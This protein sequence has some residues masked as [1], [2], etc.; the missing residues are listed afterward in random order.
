MCI[1]E[2][3]NFKIFRG[4]MPPAPLVY[5]C[6]WQSTLCFRRACYYQLV[7]L[8]IILR[9]L[10]TQKDVSFFSRKGCTFRIMQ[11]YIFQGLLTWGPLKLK[12]HPPP[13]KLRTR[14]CIRGMKNATFESSLLIVIVGLWC[15]G[16]SSWQ[17][18]TPLD[19]FEKYDISDLFQSICDVIENCKIW[20]MMS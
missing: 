16:S 9:I 11:R 3:L 4:S 5:S 8:S 17:L 14:L 12:V 13:K 15:L 20:W 6:L 19:W 18:S 7:V 2:K 1:L 10:I